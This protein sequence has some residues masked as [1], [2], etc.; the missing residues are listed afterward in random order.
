MGEDLIL[1]PARH[2]LR[3]LHERFHIVR[4]RTLPE[5][6][7][8][9]GPC[10]TVAVRI[11]LPSKRLAPIGV[12]DPS[13]ELS[14]CGIARLAA[15]IWQSL[16]PECPPGFSPIPRAASTPCTLGDDAGGV[17]VEWLEDH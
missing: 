9:E 6:L 2:R 14:D 17:T 1:L 7:L 15:V 3:R 12:F 4:H 8:K 5:R 11:A 13:V 16:R 10:P